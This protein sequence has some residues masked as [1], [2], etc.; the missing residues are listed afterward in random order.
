MNIYV[1]K[2]QFNNKI[3]KSNPK[4]DEW[5]SV[6][7]KP[8]TKNEETKSDSMV[9]TRNVGDG[10]DLGKDTLLVMNKFASLVEDILDY[11]SGNS[12]SFRVQSELKGT[13]TNSLTG[14]IRR[15]PLR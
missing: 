3:P 5:I 7:K 1:P 10:D 9:P 4:M 14:P 8:A 2:Q 15:M 11:D 13:K 12:Q 6:S